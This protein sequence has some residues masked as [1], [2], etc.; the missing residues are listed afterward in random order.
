[1]V[2]A[3]PAGATMLKLAACLAASAVTLSILAAGGRLAAVP[4][5]APGAVGADALTLVEKGQFLHHGTPYCWYPYG[6]AGPG[7]YWCGHGTHVGIG[8]GGAYGWKG[9][10][11]PRSHRVVRATPGQRFRRYR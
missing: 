8:W 2:L 10:V 1:M 9:W 6:W 7:W 5:A 4:I 3:E 11:V